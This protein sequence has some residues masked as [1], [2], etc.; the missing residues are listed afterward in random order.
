[1]LR[2]RPAYGT[3]IRAAA[4]LPAAPCPVKMYT[5]DVAVLETFVIRQPVTRA[6]L[7]EIFGRRIG[8][9]DPGR[10]TACVVIAN[11]PRGPVPRLAA[12]AR[13]HGRLPRDVWA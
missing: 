1:M 3:V 13:H 2:T 4:D 8:A 12:D 6:E 5:F 10:L 7:A 9:E 11:G